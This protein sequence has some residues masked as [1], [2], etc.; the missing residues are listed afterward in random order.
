LIWRAN[1][2]AL[3]SAASDYYAR[4]VSAAT[5]PPQPSPVDQASF[6]TSKPSRVR[7]SLGQ[8]T[9]SPALLLWFNETSLQYIGT[10]IRLPSDGPPRNSIVFI[11]HRWGKAPVSTGEDAAGREDLRASVGSRLLRLQQ[12]DRNLN[13]KRSPAHRT[14]ARAALREQTQRSGRA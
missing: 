8:Y 12:V 11:G 4:D 3:D 2:G 6:Q 14:S 5:D 13:V 10:T 9:N 7:S 1:D